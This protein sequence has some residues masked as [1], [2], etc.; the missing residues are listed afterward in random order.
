MAALIFIGVLLAAAYMGFR[1]APAAFRAEVGK[2]VREVR[3]R[4]GESHGLKLVM[5]HMVDTMLGSVLPSISKSYVPNEMSF[6]LHPADAGRWGGYFDQLAE[7]LRVFM[8]AEFRRRPELCLSDAGLAITLVTDAGA[9][10]GRPTFAARMVRAPTP[11][12]PDA[13]RTAVQVEAVTAVVASTR[14]VVRLSDG[15]DVPIVGEMTIG[16]DRSADI[17]IHRDDIS[18]RH[19]R[20]VLVDDRV[21]IVDLHSTNGTWVNDERVVMAMLERGDEVRCGSELVATVELVA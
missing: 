2:S 17:A 13:R 3:L 20:L 18:R 8:L 16:R 5:E 21:S 7:V 9:A 19:A 12:A 11:P 14:W 6:G 4:V 1:R 10:P 15:G